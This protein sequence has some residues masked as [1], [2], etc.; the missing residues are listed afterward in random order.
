[1]LPSQKQLHKGERRT[2]AYTKDYYSIL[3]LDAQS[4]SQTSTADIRRAYKL[5]LLAAHPDKNLGAAQQQQQAQPH[6]IDTVR[7]AYNIL[8]TPSTKAEYDNYLLHHPTLTASSHASTLPPPSSDFILGLEVLDLSD[9]DVLD[10]GFKFSSEAAD[11]D[12]EVE[13]NG[14]MEWTRACR[15]GMEKGYVIL[16]EEL[17]DA[18]SRGE[19]EVL[20][21]C[22]GCSLWVRVGFG[23]EEDEDEG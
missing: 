22:E 21:G 7:E 5:A 2:M 17:E 12:V 1:L 23:V 9:F 20:V 18:E 15:C 6:T 14:Q 13:R 4:S 19:G 16:E 11:E 3:G 8:S 10:P